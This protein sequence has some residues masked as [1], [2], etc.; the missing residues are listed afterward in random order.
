[1]PYRSAATIVFL[2]KTP[3]QTG[4]FSVKKAHTT[5]PVKILLLLTTSSPLVFES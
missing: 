2:M 4:F 5:T 3:M 1:M